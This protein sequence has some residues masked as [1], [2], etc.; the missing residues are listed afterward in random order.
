MK[1]EELTSSRVRR[2]R[3]LAVAGATVAAILPWLAARAAGVEFDVV[4]GGRPMVV[5]LPLV[6]ATALVVSLAGWGALAL[7]ERRTARARRIWTA[8]AVAVLLLS[9]VPLPTVETETA[10]RACLVLMHIAVGAV[11]I[12]GLRATATTDATTTVTAVAAGAS[13]RS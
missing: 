3:A 4:S 10:T 1:S 2:R 8:I 5:G 13:D 6:V 9:L 12:P 11:L 7:L